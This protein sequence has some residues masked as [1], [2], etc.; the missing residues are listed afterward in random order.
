MSNFIIRDYVP[1]D[2]ED[3][4]EL[5]LDIGLGNSQRGDN[6]EVIAQTLTSGGRLFVL[7]NKNNNEILGTSWLTND[8]RR[9]YLHHFGIKKEY[10]GKGLSKQLMEASLKFAVDCGL[11]IKIEVHKENLVALNLYKKYGFKYLGDYDVYI[12][13]N[14]KDI[15]I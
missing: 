6:A 13:R 5:W 4:I 11:Q 12:V 1:C 2:Y 15:K 7:A 14:L 3:V 8:K 10:Q 9:L